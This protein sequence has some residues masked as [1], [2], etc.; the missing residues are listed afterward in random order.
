M[1]EYSLAKVQY[2]YL[3]T[4]T[5]LWGC[6]FG[7]RGVSEGSAWGHVESCAGYAACLRK[8]CVISRAAPRKQT[9][10]LCAVL[11]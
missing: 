8:S 11:W 10:A 2:Y 5:L 1:N 3:P 7:Q 4:G 6:L 9:S